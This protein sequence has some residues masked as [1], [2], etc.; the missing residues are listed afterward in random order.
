MRRHIYIGLNDS[1]LQWLRDGVFA[2][3]L[4][5]F[6]G[7]H[8][9]ISEITKINQYTVVEITN[10]D[11]RSPLKRLYRFLKRSNITGVI[12]PFT[13]I[14]L[15]NAHPAFVNRWLTDGSFDENGNWTPGPNLCPRRQL[16][17]DPL[18]TLQANFEYDPG[19]DEIQVDEIP[20]EIDDPPENEAPEMRRAERRRIG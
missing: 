3:D 9:H 18:P 15:A 12:G 13:L 5:D 11:E 19:P 16:F 6:Y 1:K 20:G 10:N 8:F 2:F 17:G 14:Q 7:H 4:V